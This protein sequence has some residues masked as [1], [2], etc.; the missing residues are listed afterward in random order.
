MLTLPTLLDHNNRSRADILDDSR[1]YHV[2]LA[3]AYSGEPVLEYEPLVNLAKIA[4]LYAQAH[5]RLDVLMR[6]SP[7]A[8][9]QEIEAQ[10]ADLLIWQ[11]R[12]N[13]LG[14]GSSFDHLVGFLIQS[15]YESE[16]MDPEEQRHMEL[17]LAGR[18]DEVV[19][20]TEPGIDVYHY[21]QY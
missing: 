8:T 6:R 12:A 13:S 4:C 20:A 5:A 7:A 21:D 18:I 16:M 3:E 19:V 14:L 9:P 17:G 15:R 10:E 1:P 2:R 11:E